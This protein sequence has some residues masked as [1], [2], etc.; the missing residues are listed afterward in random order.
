MGALQS[1]QWV[2]EPEPIKDNGEPIF[3]KSNARVTAPHPFVIS[4]KQQKPIEVKD[5]DII[6]L[7]NDEYHVEFW[8]KEL[9]MRF[10]K[11]V[12]SFV[13][14]S[15]FDLKIPITKSQ[16][17]GYFVLTSYDTSGRVSIEHLI[18]RVV[19]CLR[20]FV[21]EVTVLIPVMS[22]GEKTRYRKFLDDNNHQQVQILDPY[23]DF[24]GGILNKDG[25]GY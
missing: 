14:D 15:P 6:L 25:F 17:V 5:T 23:K 20:P 8:K 13:Y 16:A 22:E 21:K 11:E 24:E 1:I 4:I 10:D 3:I 9:H 2:I 18:C 7:T 12:K 19:E